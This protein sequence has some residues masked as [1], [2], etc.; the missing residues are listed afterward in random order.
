MLLISV[1]VGIACGV[2]GS[3]FSK[4]ISFV[5]ALRADYH[6]LVFL[7]PIGGLATVALYKLLKSEGKGTK[8]VLNS[9]LGNSTVPV[10]L[11]PSIFAGTVISHLFGASVGREGAAL[12]IGGS[13]SS[14]VSKIFRIDEE[15]SRILTVCGMGAT[16]SALFGTPIGACIFAI[17]VLRKLKFGLISFIPTL[18][19]S[20]T[21]YGIALL[22]GESGERFELYSVPA[23]DFSVLWRVVVI[24]A[25]TGI[26][27][28]LFCS[29]LHISEHHAAKLIKNPY[30]RIFAGGITVILL[31]V[32]IGS[33]DYNGGGIFVIER[34]LESGT[35]IPYAFLLKILFTVISNSAGY[36]GG[37][38]VPSFFIGATF[39]ATAAGFVGLS[40]PFGAA[41]GMSAIFS[42][43]TSC[44]VATCF[45]CAE[46]MGIEALPFFIVSSIISAV[47][48]GKTSLFH[49]S[50]E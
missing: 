45:I 50:K 17:E 8:T 48:S 33:T 32:V 16:F 23:F 19:S 11:L 2:T 4:S 44:P 27:G 3:F 35:V 12:Q 22:M 49:S 15:T 31:T 13:I 9:T 43:V 42:A 47:I 20:F 18:I 10:G 14:L 39:G 36:K 26:V 1:L 5:T 40:V 24:S 28:F 37:E 29:V 7:L 41:V 6:W 30:I 46:V 34:I 21:A 25:A 38:I